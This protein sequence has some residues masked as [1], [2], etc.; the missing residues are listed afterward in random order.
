M[1]TA[2]V[3]PTAGTATPTGSVQFATRAST[4]GSVMLTAGVASLSATLPA[5]SHTI[6]ATYSGD[7]VYP[8]AS[9][10][11]TQVVSA[12]VEALSLAVSD[13]APVFG[14]PVT[15]T[16]VGSRSGTVEFTDGGT[17]LGSAAVLSGVA[18]LTLATLTAGTHV[19][20]ASSGAV[21]AELTLTVSKAATTTALVFSKRSAVARVKA[22]AGLPSGSVRFVNAATGLTIS[23]APVVDG[24]ASIAWES[25]DSLVAVYTGDDNFLASTSAAVNPLTVANAASY[26][27]ESFAPDEMVA[28]F[29]PNLGAGIVVE[30]VDSGGNTRKAEVLYAAEDQAAIVMP[31]DAAPGAAVLR[32]RAMSAAIMIAPTSPGVFTRD[33]SGTGAAAGTDEPNPDADYVVLYGT[34]IR[35]YREK[36]TCTVEGRPAEVLYAGAQGAFSGLD[37]VNVLLPTELRAA[38]AVSLVLTVDGVAANAVTV[39]APG[40]RPR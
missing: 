33:S 36:P 20:S 14:Q 24:M 27:A 7:A 1:F 22:A 9:A 26:S 5:G 37:Q 34:G 4:L 17:V 28:V 23:A 3:T 38:G 16:V 29:G 8:A 31:S 10:T 13:K 25:G 21:S 19:I 15:F 11:L 6:T 40:A 12:V 2:T 32:V 30:V 18:Q 35:H 39:I